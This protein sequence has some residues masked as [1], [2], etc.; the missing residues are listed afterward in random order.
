MV[1]FDVN[2][3]FKRLSLPKLGISIILFIL[4]TLHISCS[5]EE[6]W[7]RQNP[8]NFLRNYLYAV[9][10]QAHDAVWSFLSS[11]SQNHLDR[12]AK[13]LAVLTKN[14]SYAGKDMLRLGHVL[15]S[16]REYKKFELLSNDGQR[17]EVE[18][19]RHEG[20]SLYIQLTREHG[21]WKITLPLA[22]FDIEKEQR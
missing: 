15:S 21:Q 12:R 11:E 14:N 22:D 2:L 13:A 19:I 1:L 8:S 10:I 20:A 5:G 6:I 17:A 16:T 18:I 9:D 4:A 7:E 3:S